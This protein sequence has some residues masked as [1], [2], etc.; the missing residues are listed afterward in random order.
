MA[1]KAYKIYGADGHRNAV[2]FDK[3]FTWDFSTEK[4]GKRVL[5]VLN[6]D[7]TG[8]NDYNIL[9]VHRNT[10]AECEAE[11][12]GQVSDGLYE[13]YRTGKQESV[14]KEDLDKYME[15]VFAEDEQEYKDIWNAWFNAVKDS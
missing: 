11:K 13:N 10:A 12:N 8:T 5:I 6:S 7:I 9:I 2:S 15:K 1:Y 14:S 4:E 3:S